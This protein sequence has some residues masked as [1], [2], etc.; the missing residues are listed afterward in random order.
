MFKN[1]KWRIGAVLLAVVILAGTISGIAFADT[2]LD[3]SDKPDF[4]AIYQSFISKL[5]DN[6][7]VTE[8]ELEQ[9]MEDTQIAM[10]NDAVTAGTI[11]QEQADKTIE[12]IES[13]E[14]CGIMGLDFGHRTGGPGPGGDGK[15]PSSGNNDKGPGPAH[16]TQSNVN[17]GNS[18][19]K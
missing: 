15:G 4:T 6:L 3:K 13:G 14:G 5:A 7:G 17:T 1:S 11:T 16:G 12:R 18:T 9:A 19:N 2:S 8:D 10:I